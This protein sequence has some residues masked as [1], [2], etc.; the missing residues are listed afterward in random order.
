MEDRPL[1]TLHSL[2]GVVVAAFLG[3]PV[4][5]GIIMAINYRRIG[6]KS[7]ARNVAVFGV[8]ATAAL[9]AILF[10]IPD[11][12]L[13][14]I[15]NPVFIALQLALVYMFA[16]SLQHG[17]IQK[18]IANGGT[19]ASVWPS[20]GIGAL[21]LPVVLGAFIGA[22]FLLEPSF[23]TVVEF[24]NDEIYYSGEATEDDARKLARVLKEVEFFGST[25]ASV[26]LH[27][28]SGQYTISFAL[29]EN[30]WRDIQTVEAFRDIGRTVAASVFSTPL[31][32]HLCDGYF[33]AKETIRIE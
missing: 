33:S 25:G 12:T 30:A 26:Q 10:A 32:I 29:E 4:A 31:E 17:L 8:I 15:P 27:A 23:G 7:A 14:R 21:C 3:A 11:D 6:R 19:I 16:K 5:A 9:L 1:Y 18:H 24:G 13:D 28:S 2:R 20:V 22:A